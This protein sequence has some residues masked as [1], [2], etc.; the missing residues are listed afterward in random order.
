MGDAEKA[1]AEA[2]RLRSEIT[3]AQALA[4]GPELE[5]CVNTLKQVRA[6]HIHGHTCRSL[7]EHVVD[8]SSTQHGMKHRPSLL[9]HIAYVQRAFW[10]ACHFL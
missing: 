4:D 7:S 3:A 1:I 5:K 9:V 6:E 2:T 8:P 10:E